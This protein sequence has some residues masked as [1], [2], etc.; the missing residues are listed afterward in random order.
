MG[1]YTMQSDLISPCVNYLVDLHV[2][3]ALDRR[4]NG[5]YVDPLTG[6]PVPSDGMIVGRGGK[7]PKVV[8]NDYGDYMEV[9]DS[10]VFS[11]VCNI[12][13]YTQET[14][15]EVFDAVIPRGTPYYISRCGDIV[16]SERLL[17]KGKASGSVTYEE[18]RDVTWHV[19]KLIPKDEVSVGWLLL[20]DGTYIHPL[21]WSDGIA[22]DVIGFVGDIYGH[23][24]YV[25]G[26]E[27]V[28]LSDT[29]CGMNLH[30]QLFYYGEYINQ[31]VVHSLIRIADKYHTIGTVPYQWCV[32]TTSMVE[33]IIRRNDQIFG[34]CIRLLNRHFTPFHFVSIEISQGTGSVRPWSVGDTYYESPLCILPMSIRALS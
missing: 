34:Y 27:P 10:H 31:D 19:E 26:R 15:Y 24:A 8:R 33:D 11:Y 13:R 1:L 21:G 30:D 32:P 7:S 18:W 16:A 3:K 2:L 6:I 5:V 17:L 20:S 9:N 23:T 22:D 4:E 25:W 29:A 14:G 12:T 28:A